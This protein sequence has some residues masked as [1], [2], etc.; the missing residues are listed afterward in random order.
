MALNETDILGGKAIIFQN[1]FDIW[2]FRTWVSEEKQYVRKSLKTK[3]KHQAT[4]DAEDMYFQIIS[5]VRNNEKIFGKKIE[6]AIVPFLNFKK[7]QVGV[8]NEITIVIGR[9]KTIEAHLRHFVRYIGI[10]TKITDLSSNFLTSYYRDGELTDYVSYR[11]NLDASPS[12]IKN[13]ISTIGSCFRFLY[14]EGH[15]SLRKIKFPVTTKKSNDIDVE[16]IR[17]QTFTR[18]EYK[19][20]TTALS[21]SYIAKYN[22]LT[23]NEMFDRQLARHYFLFA[24]NSGMRSGELRKLKW[25]DVEVTTV[26]GGNQQEERLAKISVPALNTKVR[27]SRV[28]Y[29]M[30]AIYLER[31]GKDFAKHKTG[32]IFS[33]DGTTEFNN[34]FFNKHFRNIM[35][36]SKIKKERAKALVPYSLRHFCITQRVMSGCSFGDVA[37]MCGTSSK[38]V[39]NTYFHLNEAMMKRTALARYKVIDGVNVPITNLLDETL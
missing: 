5:R 17:R 25:E 10:N 15:H 28:F 22:K 3:D 35:K 32:Y 30:G 39:E 36:I 9:Y 16:L 34:S 20:F 33:R 21:K 19:Q 8:G 31:W 4:N 13:E 11:S 18:D 14:D 23:T 1:D 2:Q 29:C 38:Q 6:E 27:K 24:A 37:L 26:G 12:T 7:R